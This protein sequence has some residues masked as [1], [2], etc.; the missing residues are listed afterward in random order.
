MPKRVARLTILMLLVGSVCA[1]AASKNEDVLRLPSL[2]MFEGVSQVVSADY[3]YSGHKEGNRSSSSSNLRERYA[4]SSVFSVL[5]PHLANLQINAGLSYNQ[6]FGQSKGD[7]LN[8]NYDVITS[9]FDLSHHP[10]TVVASHGESVIS[11]GYTPTYTISTDNYQLHAALL[12][13][14]VPVEFFLNRNSSNSKGL[15]VDSSQSGGSEQIIMRHELPSSHTSGT[16]SHT[17]SRMQGDDVDGYSAMLTNVLTLDPLNNYQL[18]SS[19][20]FSQSKGSTTQDKDYSF[21]ES[22]SCRFGQAL[23]GG[24]VYRY[25]YNSTLSFQGESQSVSQNSLS[26]SLRHQLFQSLTTDVAAQA[27]RTS[28]L[29]GEQESYGSH[30]NLNYQKML[31]AKGRLS[32]SFGLRQ[33]VTSQDLAAS[34]LTVRDEPHVVAEQGEEI[35]PKVE[36]QLTSVFSVRSVTP[37]E[38]VYL[39]G[40]DYAVDRNLG[41]ITV[42]HGGA[43]APGTSLLIS[44]IIDYNPSVKY[45]SSG[46]T[47]ASQYSILDGRYVLGASMSSQ[48]EKLL[49]GEA[50]GRPLGDS[51]AYALSASANYTKVRMGVEFNSFDSTVQSYSRI[52]G[53]WRYSATLEDG[54]RVSLNLNDNYTMYPAEDGSAGYSVNSATISGGYS[55]TFFQFLRFSSSLAASDVRSESS[56][57][58]FIMFRGGVSGNYNQLLFSLNGTTKYRI[59]GDSTKV[60]NSLQCTVSRFF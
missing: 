48:S 1:H 25:E 17:S 22:L 9:L 44:Y 47:L 35:V 42:L 34:S 57:S 33:D 6:K 36:G 53:F 7:V 37:T 54:A 52:I 16:V 59:A 2:L 19:A 5:D 18:G 40:V 39:E 11:N 15:E 55:R 38:I 43:I 49:S 41:R 14:T 28:L 30:L 31:P 46:Q 50:T 13:S 21:E 20:S 10:M 58:N 26:A 24:F 3:T 56:S 32:I 29:G 27:S 8:Y 23:T 12:H 4:I 45:L 51:K 60:D